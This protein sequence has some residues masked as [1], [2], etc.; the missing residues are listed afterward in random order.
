MT[1]EIYG[2][3]GPSCRERETLKNMI[4]AGMTGIRLNS[5]H[6]SLSASADMTAN[7]RSAEAECGVS[8][9]LMIDLQG[10]EVR[11]GILEEPLSLQES[12]EIREDLLCLPVCVSDSLETNDRIL[13][14]DGK[15]LLQKTADG[16]LRVLR[17]GVLTSRKS[18]K[19]ENRTVRGPLLTE[20]DLINISEIS[21]YGVT[22]VMQPFVSCGQD[23]R[24]VRRILNENGCGGVRLFAKIETMEGVSNLPDIIPECDVIVIARGDLGNNMPLWDLPAVQKDIEHACME[25]GRDFMVVTQMLTSMIEN[26]VPTRAEVSDIFNAVVDGAASVMVT[27]ETASGKYPAE[28]IRYLAMTARSAERYRIMHGR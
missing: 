15:I 21:T 1:T 26:P 3:I 12:E 17:G 7:L 9:D 19:I 22:S 28:T 25:S 18:V 4:L 23:L 11:I 6:A 24:A 14:D 8:V 13:L 20:Q 10:P 2:T 27:N 5:S 16:T